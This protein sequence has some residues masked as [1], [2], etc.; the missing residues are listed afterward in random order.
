[1]EKYKGLGAVIHFFFFTSAL[2]EEFSDSHPCC[3]I[4]GKQF[5]VPIGDLYRERVLPLQGLQKAT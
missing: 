3:F 2:V 4:S 5:P 1:M